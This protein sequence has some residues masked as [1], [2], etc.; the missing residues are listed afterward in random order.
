MSK[1][2]HLLNLYISG[3]TTYVDSV[4][5]TLQLH[6]LLPKLLRPISLRLCGMTCKKNNASIDDSSA[7]GKDLPLTQ[8]A[9]SASESASNN[10]GRNLEVHIATDLPTL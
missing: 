1:S 9:H 7:N 3:A 6:T 4:H 8:Q 2:W 5:L 10:K